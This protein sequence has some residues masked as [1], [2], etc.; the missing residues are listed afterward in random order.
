MKILG[1]N[2]YYHDSSAAIIE[3]GNVICAIEEERL[4]RKKHDNNFPILSVNKCLEQTS[5]N[6]SDIDIVCYYEKPLLKFER[7]LEGI[8]KHFPKSYKMFIDAI[9][10]WLNEK[11]I[12]EKQIRKKLNYSGKIIFSN[13]HLSHAAAAFYTSNFNKATVITIDGVG[14]YQTTVIWRANKNKLVSVKEII[15]PNS[16]G[17]LYSTFTSFLGFEVNEGEYKLMGLAAYGKPKYLK[18]VFSLLDVNTDGS[19]RLIM[20]YFA[21]EYKNKM[22]SKKFEDE[23]G[24]PVKIGQ[25]YTQYY[26]DLAASIQKA[27]EILVLGIVNY[28][29][30]ITGNDNLCL[31]GGVALNAVINGKIIT[32]SPYKNLFVFG[33]SGDGGCAIG[34]ALLA[35]KLFEK[36]NTTFQTSLL[37]GPEYSD[38]E[39]QNVLIKKELNYKKIA[40]DQ[41]V[42]FTVQKLIQGKVV[43]LFQGKMEFGPRALGNRSIISSP[44][45]IKQK[46]IV[47]KIKIREQFRPFAAVTIDEKIKTYFNN[48]TGIDLTMMNTCLTVKEG[49][50][51]KIPAVTHIDGTC[52]VQSVKKDSGFIYKLTKEFGNRTGTAVLLNTSFN[53]KGQPLVESPE[54]AIDTYL[55]TKIDILVIGSFVLSKNPIV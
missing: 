3:N 24:L 26:M 12:I 6:I 35:S 40:E 39:I 28:S 10:E 15:Y 34:G 30:K 27:M 22:W 21:F 33:S 44:Y 32:N 51:S 20:E 4:S 23:F 19:F 11:I 55:K 7:I 54:Q 45:P 43:A 52:R 1:I 13:H 25:K 47:N 5:L 14:E 31:G 9:P 48:S 53:L 42:K 29:H 49:F 18:K 16:L 46:E 2:A 38:M 17:L 50:K 41:K 8:V 36:R 37:L